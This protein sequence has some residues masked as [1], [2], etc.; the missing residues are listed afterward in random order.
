[1]FNLAEDFDLINDQKGIKIEA[2]RFFYKCLKR[3]CLFNSF[4]YLFL[5]LDSD[6]LLSY[7]LLLHLT[8]LNIYTHKNKV[9][10]FECD[11]HLF[12]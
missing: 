10:H 12:C 6:S 11:K 2:N 4:L 5:K 7:C 8:D 9:V 1:M 3:L